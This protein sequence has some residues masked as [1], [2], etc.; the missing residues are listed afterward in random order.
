MTETDPGIEPHDATAI[1]AF[2]DALWEF[3][4]ELNRLHIEYGAPSY[5]VMASASVTPRLTKAGLNEMLSGRRFTSVETLLEFI[6]VLT[7]AQPQARTEL[8]DQWRGRWRDVKL[9]QRQAQPA[10]K[11]LRATVR[12]M[13]DDAVQE[14]QAVRESARAEADR[15]LAEA[16][17]DAG[18]LRAEAHK[19]ANELLDRARARAGQIRSA[20]AGEGT[21]PDVSQPAGAGRSWWRRGGGLAL[22]PALGPLTV[23]I[24]V[25]ALALTAILA[26]D[27]FIE[28]PGDCQA[29]VADPLTYRAGLQ[30]RGGVQQ[31][32]LAIEP[33]SFITLSPH[34]SLRPVFG[35]PSGTPSHSSPEPSPTP[36][37]E[38]TAT[39]TP[40]P[41][42]TPSASP[43]QNKLD[44]CA[45]QTPPASP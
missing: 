5:A 22:R 36:S 11:R 2:E 4:R 14:A 15:I 28:T 27:S 41:S 44:P 23:A 30:G 31:A 35:F 3:T 29:R 39:P 32:A 21:A 40:S 42:P 7:T 8:S 6:R 37:T 18:R 25:V 38:P 13:L 20:S 1:T 12:Q 9:L 24:A 16:E 43:T 10:S 33:E 26:G 45:P 17:V 34:Y 19:D